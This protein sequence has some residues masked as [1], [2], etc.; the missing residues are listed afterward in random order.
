MLKG[1]TFKEMP[2]CQNNNSVRIS[3]FA[4]TAEGMRLPWE[5]QKELWTPKFGVSDLALSGAERERKP[6][7]NTAQSRERLAPRCGQLVSRL[8]GA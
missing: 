7:K 5:L 4:D 3:L 6:F 8:V 2:S 1:K